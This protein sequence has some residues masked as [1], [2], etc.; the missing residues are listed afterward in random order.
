MTSWEILL[1]S[2]AGS[3]CHWARI[4]EGKVI[5]EEMRRW[6][7]RVY[8]ES[9]QLNGKLPLKSKRINLILK[10]II[11]QMRGLVRRKLPVIK[12]IQIEAQIKCTPQVRKD[13][14]MS[15]RVSG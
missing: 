14:A 5:E 1:P 12:T 3:R 4:E 11:R 10:E 6:G 13:I 15:K 7:Q 8:I 2:R 9:I